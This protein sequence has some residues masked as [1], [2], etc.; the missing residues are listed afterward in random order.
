MNINIAN[1]TCN[2]IQILVNH[3]I[4][5]A[6]FDKTVQA[7]IEECVDKTTGKYKITYQGASFYAYSENIDVTYLKNTA[8]FVLFP[9]NDASAAKQILGAVSKTATSYLTSRGDNIYN[10]IGSNC[11]IKQPARIELSSFSPETI[12]L[13]DKT[14]NNN[15]INIDTV[16]VEEYI[17]K[18]S[19]LYLSAIFRTNLIKEQKYIGNYGFNFYFDYVN[20]HGENYLEKAVFDINNMKG[21]PYSFTSDTKQSKVFNINTAGFQGINKIE[22]FVKD[23]PLIDE[24]KK[25][26]K[27]IFIS[28]IECFAA[29]KMNEEELSGSFLTINTTK[30]TLFTK[31]IKELT[32]LAEIK[33]KG[34]PIS[35]NP[36]HMKFF[37]FRE[38]VT[39]NSGE[40]FFNPYGGEGWQCLNTY[41]VLS[42]TEEEPTQ[43]EWNNGTYDLILDKNNYNTNETKI[44]CVVLYDE[45]VLTKE[46][47]IKNLDDNIFKISLTSN[48]GEQFNFDTITDTTPTLKCE[49]YKNNILSTDKFIYYWMLDSMNNSFNILEE[50]E[51]GEYQIVLNS[52]KNYATFRCGVSKKNSD[53]SIEYI[54]TASIKITN[55]A[56]NQAQFNL[57]IENGNQVFKYDVDGVSPISKRQDNPQI[58]LPFKAILYDPTGNI[59]NENFLNIT[60]E[61]PTENSLL[62]TKEGNIKEKPGYSIHKGNVLN[63]SIAEIYN[64]AYINNTIN[65]IVEYQGQIYKTTTNLLFLKEG[66]PGTNGTDIVCRI[67]PNTNETINEYPMVIKLDNAKKISYNKNNEDNFSF[68]VEMW[69]GGQQIY[70][71]SESAGEFKITWDILK[72]YSDNTNIVIKDKDKG[73]F[74]WN[75]E[76][77]E[78][79]ANIIK[80]TVRY[81]GKNYY[82]TLPLI[83]I[84]YNSQIIKDFASIDNYNIKLMYQSGFRYATY[85]SAGLFPKYSNAK[86]FTIVSDKDSNFN[87]LWSIIGISLIN[88]SKELESNQQQISPITYFDGSTVNNALKCTVIENN[89]EIATIHIPIHLL[90][91]QY[92]ITQINEWDGNTIDIDNEGGTILSPQ[93]GAGRKNIDNTFTGLVMGVVKNGAITQT[94]LFGFNSGKQTIL[95]DADTGKAEF[96]VGTG[97]IIL[98]PTNNTA[99]IQGGGYDQNNKTGMEI[100]LTE[101]SIKW[102]NGKFKVDKEGNL[103][104]STL[105]SEITSVTEKINNEVDARKELAT[106]TT[107]KFEQTSQDITAAIST[108]KEYTNGVKENLESSLKITNEAITA[109]VKARKEG[110]NAL[111]T[112][113]TQTASE[114]RQEVKDADNQLQSSLNTQAGQIAAKVSSTEDGESCSWSLTKDAFSI[115]KSSGRKDNNLVFKVDAEGLTVNGK[116]QFTGKV[117]AT[118]G[119]IGGCIIDTKGNLQ[120]K[121]ANISEKLTANQIDV[122]SINFTSFKGGQ[123]LS[124]NVSDNAINISNEVERAKKAEEDLS[125]AITGVNDGLTAYVKADTTGEQTSWKLTKDAFLVYSK[126]SST[127]SNVE[128]LKVDKNGL[129]VTG[130]IT[131]TKGTFNNCIIE[132]TCTIKGRLAFDN[133]PDNVATQEFATNKASDAEKNAKTAASGY[134]S[135]AEINAKSAAQGYANTAENN[136]KSHT[137]TEITKVNA[138]IAAVSEGLEAKVSNESGTES[139]GWIIKTDQFT[140]KG[141]N[142]EVLKVTSSGLS[143]K[144]TVTATSGTFDNCTINSNCTIKG[145]LSGA[146]GNFTGEI[147]ATSG[148]I[149][150]LTLTDKLKWE[151][152]CYISPSANEKLEEYYLSF[153]GFQVSEY[154]PIVTGVI[155]ANSG[156]FKNCTIEDSCVIKGA[157]QGNTIASNSGTSGQGSITYIDYLNGTFSEYIIKLQDKTLT[158]SASVELFVTDQ[159]SRVLLS[160][161]MGS[162]TVSQNNIFLNHSSMIRLWSPSFDIDCDNIQLYSNNIAIETSIYFTVGEINTTIGNYRTW[163]RIQDD[164]ITLKSKYIY[165]GR[166]NGTNEP[167]YGYLYGNWY[168][169]ASIIVSSDKNKKHNIQ[170]ISNSYE[171]LFENLIPRLYKY[172]DNN[173]NRIHTGFIAQEV[174]E[175][176]KKAGLTTQDLAAFVQVKNNDAQETYLAL[177]YEEFIALNTY[178]IQKQK[179]KIDILE[180]QLA[181]QQD[182]I[183]KL[184]NYLGL[185]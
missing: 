81:Q 68:L 22:C 139:F 126:A 34:E 112:S 95:L 77:L 76:I 87:Y 137:N 184:L 158:Q 62:L 7:T 11:I 123:E 6:A 79:P 1:E 129:K 181:Q 41:T 63:Y 124:N 128:V 93:V 15:L 103:E 121:N 75:D 13:Y 74:S 49:V 113:I 51:K 104:S 125:T 185:S 18:H 28:S 91:N 168:S 29:T 131:A 52:I 156:V 149:G 5:N 21:S 140:I 86:P 100:N 182:K 174:Y 175:A 44:K 97:K 108:S 120:I 163:G 176:I 24:N 55:E 85:T 122:A 33:I 153:P 25:E 39:V 133:L 45:T 146:T 17:K 98:D 170:L 132:D 151:N 135:T 102:G 160:A 183:N 142:E 147:T 2:A 136:A 72:N 173:S 31:D 19:L 167:T 99:V 84:E 116:G 32:L 43:I 67:I 134:A 64:A 169:Q 114:I 164:Q 159:D 162:L 96:G 150:N 144:G 36:D 42:G 65:L 70:R 154:G 47:I 71:G 148:S 88:E 101:P 16:A 179:N 94:G 118:E 177:R 130:E 178:M 155:N 59:I 145:V 111:S 66:D 78:A 115:F 61:V 26:Q 119:E 161:A 89:V 56:A 30:G 57:V 20:E 27:D 4:T 166:E 165:L 9:G 40:V 117:T 109:E 73:I 69:K 141:N 171:I 54:G 46:I 60:W 107:S 82:A 35:I 80:A 12:V 8:V 50:N 14:L 58:L 127:A 38:N 106:Q 143:V 172:N 110:E 48:V 10:Y 53:G 157:L 138:S 90:L 23:F 3:A 37:W 105:N 180:N 83:S 92:G 152:G